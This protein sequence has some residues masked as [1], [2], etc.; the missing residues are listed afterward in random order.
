[1][2]GSNFCPGVKETIQGSADLNHSGAGTLASRPLASFV[3]S[4]MEH[5]KYDKIKIN[6]SFCCIKDW[7]LPQCQADKFERA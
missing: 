3:A 6:I 4:N 2:S 1:M 7:P 5:A